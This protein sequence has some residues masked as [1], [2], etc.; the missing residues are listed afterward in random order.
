MNLLKLTNKQTVFLIEVPD[1]RLKLLRT[2]LFG[3]KVYFDFHVNIFTKRSLENLFAKYGYGS[4][5]NYKSTPYR[6]VRANVING[7]VMKNLNTFNT[8]ISRI[9]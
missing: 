8:K 9:Y 7:L 3:K 4:L 1:E 2:T 5:I 6:G